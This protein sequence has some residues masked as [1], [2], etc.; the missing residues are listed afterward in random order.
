[1]RVHN[2]TIL[3][4]KKVSKFIVPLIMSLLVCGCTNNNPSSENSSEGSNSMTN[5]TVSENNSSNNVKEV[6]SIEVEGYSST[7][8]YLHNF[9]ESNVKIV[10]NYDN[11]TS[12]TYTYEKLSFDFSNFSSGK[13]GKQT[14]G[15]NVYGKDISKNIEVEVVPA[16][17]FN[18]LMIG[19]S[20]ADDTIQWVYD[21]CNNLNID[22]NIASLYIG[23]CSLD[24][25]YSNLTNNK[26][27]YAFRKY[28]NTTKTWDWT[29]TYNTSIEDAL[30]YYDWDFVSLQQASGSS[31]REA[32]YAKLDLI[33]DEILYLKE[34][35][36][37]IWNMTWAY[38]QD[39]S[40]GDFSYYDNS[41]IK[42]YNAICDV[43]ET[44]ISTNE[45]IKAIVPSGTA[46]QNA[47]TSF[48]GDNLTRDG[49]HLSLDLGRYI[50]GL[51]LVATMTGQDI[52]NITFAPSGLSATHRKLAIEAVK[53]ALANHYEV[54]NSSYDEAPTIDLS[55]HIE[56][57]YEPIASAYYFSTSA[58]EYNSM[59]TSVALSGQFVA[60]KKFTKE[61]LPV[62][63]IIE[64]KPG[65]QYRPEGWI[66]DNPQASRPG[67]ITTQFIEIDEAWWGNYIYRA[68]NV[69]KTNGEIIT[70]SIKEAS[71]ALSIYVPKDK[72][73]PVQNEFASND[74]TLFSN[75]SLDIT[76]YEMYDYGVSNGFYNSDSSNGSI[77]VESVG[78]FSTKFI[79]TELFTKDTL[80]NGTVLIIDNDYQ[81]RPDGWIEGNVS[82]GSRPGNIKTNITVVDD[83]WWGDYVVRGINI[84][85]VDGSVI[86]QLSR[87]VNQHF[88]IYIPKN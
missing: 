28:N 9:D 20:F 33:I 78:D 3:K 31:G 2:Y 77:K 8:T 12:D 85:K 55:N 82:S 22:V 86:N 58:T 56:I 64:I 30:E 63:S 14:I 53:N 18:I 46:I 39:S 4:M 34:D 57:D 65:Y 70:G 42:M 74:A 7:L 40:H 45:Y 76:K 26:K 69:S 61:E 11:D 47:R 36:S 60:S 50:A 66:D 25:H 17:S 84:S 35:V 73:T 29:N 87:E 71:E 48:V 37:F 79:C 6:E 75:N 51:S 54:T 80:P 81:Y 5:S 59:T 19:N 67:N 72:Y 16:E 52:S 83:A 15:V 68:F 41:Q 38:Q 1:M 23:G 88:R 21:I 13:L 10:V 62:G 27:A 44:K 32:T 49:Y 43:L 24:T